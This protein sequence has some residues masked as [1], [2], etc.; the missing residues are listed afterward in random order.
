MYN[1]DIV[2][3]NSLENY[4]KLYNKGDSV[5]N[6]NPLKNEHYK[7]FALSNVDVRIIDRDKVNELLIPLSKLHYFVNDHVVKDIKTGKSIFMK[8]NRF[9]YMIPIQS[10]KGNII[11]FSFRRVFDT[12][13]TNKH[14]SLNSSN[15]DYNKSAPTFFGWY[16]DFEKFDYDSRNGAKSIALC[17]GIKDCI[18]LKQFYPYVLALNGSSINAKGASFLRYLTNKVVLIPDTDKPG[19]DAFYNNDTNLT[20][21]GFFTSVVKL[22][23]GIKDA[24]SYINHPDLEH[25]IKTRLLNVLEEL[26]NIVRLK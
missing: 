12:E 26:E 9:F 10:I 18:Y 11:S 19:M 1:D 7:I 14:Y 21:A 4:I 24:A 23:K 17:E 3:D 8:G 15:E 20:K 6:I 25:I 22:D 2:T 13:R 5:H 16:K